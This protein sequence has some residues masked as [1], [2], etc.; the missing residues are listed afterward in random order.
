MKGFW[1]SLLGFIILMVFGCKSKESTLKATEYE[2]FTS[3]LRTNYERVDD[4]TITKKKAVEMEG[5][6]LM[7]VT[8]RMTEYDTDKNV[9]LRTT[10]VEELYVENNKG[11]SFENELKDINTVVND[12]TQHSAGVSKMKERETET[13][14]ESNGLKSFGKWMGIVIGI[15]IIVGFIIMMIRK[16][17]R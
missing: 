2:R 17:V 13:V 3:D 6:R 14:I 7:M 16:R 9:P 8:T 15:G 12:S 5:M 11:E 4:V 1:Y 10:E